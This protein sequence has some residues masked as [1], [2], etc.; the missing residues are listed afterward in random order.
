LEYNQFIILAVDERPAGASGCSI[1]GSVRFLKGLQHSVGIDFFNRRLVA[2][3]D[4]SSIRMHPVTE[5]KNLFEAGILSPDSVTFNNAL[6]TKEDWTKSWKISAK[7]SW[8]S[9][10]LPKPAGAPHPL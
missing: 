4:G 8:L 7:E 1:D 6:A 3:F 2:F 5:L 10:F 9:R